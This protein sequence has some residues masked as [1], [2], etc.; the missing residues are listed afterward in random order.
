MS[1]KIVDFTEALQKQRNE[2]DSIASEVSKTLK[3]GG[4]GGTFDGMEARVI[5]LE[6]LAKQTNEKLDKLIERSVKVEVDLARLDGKVTALPN[7]EAFGHLRG[8]VDSLPT[9]PKIAGL[10]GIIGVLISIAS[11]WD[12]IA[13][14]LK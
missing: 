5:A 6:A 4:G 9:I 12:K 3:S 1:N 8:R 11:N 13:A 2:T 14:L 7:A 10:F